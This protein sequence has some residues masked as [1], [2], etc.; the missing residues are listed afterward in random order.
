MNLYFL[1]RFP[2]TKCFLLSSEPPSFL[3]C[4]PPGGADRGQE[5]EQE[6][7]VGVPD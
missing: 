4:W 7:K 6:G 3:L 2:K 1:A 5:A